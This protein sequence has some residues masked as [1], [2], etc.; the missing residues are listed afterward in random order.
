MK[1]NLNLAVAPSFR[2]RFALA[3][4]VPTTLVGLVVM[5][6]LAYST[7]S[8]FRSYRRAQAE[9]AGPLSENS[10]LVEREL[11]LRRALDR[12]GLRDQLLRAQSVNA[13][14]EKRQL[15]LSAL[16]AKASSLLPSDTKLN[17]LAVTRSDNGAVVRFEV[18]ARDAEAVETFLANLTKSPDFEDAT[19]TS[20]G[21]VEQGQ[22]V[23]GSEIT[24]AC[25]ARY[26]GTTSGADEPEQVPA[27]S[28]SSESPA[29]AKAKAGNRGNAELTQNSHP[30]I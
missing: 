25:T 4:S 14:I 18:N 24:V 19:T 21:V 15:S 5:A 6:V 26:V 28:K 10:R 16:A 20:E 30:G 22:G 27:G 7:V 23:A 12:P 13:L 17:A 3:W 9:L 11:E 2:D 8:A 1:I 29:G